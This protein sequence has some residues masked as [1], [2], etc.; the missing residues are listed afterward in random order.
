MNNIKFMGLYLLVFSIAI[1]EVSG[2]FSYISFFV[3]QAVVFYAM[4]LDLKRRK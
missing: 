3:S 1:K 4:A 2:D